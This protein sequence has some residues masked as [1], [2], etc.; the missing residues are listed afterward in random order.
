MQADF[1]TKLRQVLSHERLA[2]YQ[3]R[4]RT[5]GD[6]ALF[7][8]YLWN[9]A[10]SESLYPGLQALEVALRNTIHNAAIQQFSR[11]DWYADRQ[12]IHH[13]YNINAISK[14]R[15]QLR[16]QNK[17]PDPGRIIAELSFGF[18]TSLFDSRY[19]QKLWTRLIK[20]AFP[21]MPRRIRTRKELSKRLNK[22]RN[23]RNRIFHHEP[24]WYWQDL[25]QQH[26]IL[27]ETL[28]WI[29]PAMR[30]MLTTL[31]RFPEI[32]EA[33]PQTYTLKLRCFC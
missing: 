3:Q 33:G 4:G 26:D 18:W 30:D 15:E 28:T 27:L 31:D 32:Y 22:I 6:L 19:E 9:M 10:L 17:T 29:E 7:S 1:V 20:P 24:I 2:A 13:R 11:K 21:Y 23:L 25:A 5:D 8:H 16:R 12:I 14:A